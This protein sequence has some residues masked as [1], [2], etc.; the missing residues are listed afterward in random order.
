MDTGTTITSTFAAVT[1]WIDAQN[2]FT[3]TTYITYRTMGYIFAVQDD[4]DAS[5]SY[6]FLKGWN[7][8]FNSTSSFDSKYRILQFEITSGGAIASGGQYK[9]PTEMI[10]DG[11]KVTRVTYNFQTASLIFKPGNIAIYVYI[12]SSTE[13]G[14]VLYVKSYSDIGWTAGAGVDQPVIKCGS[15]IINPNNVNTISAG[16]DAVYGPYILVFPPIGGDLPSAHYPGCIIWKNSSYS[17][18]SP[19]VGSPVQIFGS[20]LKT[21]TADSTAMYPDIEIYAM[22]YLVNYSYY[23]RKGTCWLFV[24][25]WFKPDVRQSSEVSENGWLK[26]GDEICILQNTGD[27]PTD[28]QYGQYKNQWQI[29]GWTLDADQ[30]TVTVELGDHERNTNTLINDKTSGINYTIT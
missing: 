30:M 26:A 9:S 11:E 3:N 8:A 14:M 19:T 10:K 25:D 20:I 16:T 13:S 18:S 15:D 23:Y 21:I 6:I 2:R 28:L 4:V 5:T 1:P 22:K 17:E 29:V 27:T 24:Y 12:N 7:W